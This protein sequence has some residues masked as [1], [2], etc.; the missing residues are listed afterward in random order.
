MGHSSERLHPGMDE[1]F[2]FRKGINRVEIKD[3]VIGELDLIELG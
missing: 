3:W 1:A 2:C